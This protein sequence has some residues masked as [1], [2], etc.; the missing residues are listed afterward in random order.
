MRPSPGASVRQHHSS[1]RAVSMSRAPLDG[2]ALPPGARRHLF[3]ESPRPRPAAG[4]LVRRRCRA[5]RRRLRS[6]GAD[7]VRVR[8]LKEEGSCPVGH[9][10][11]AWNWACVRLSGTWRTSGRGLTESAFL[12]RLMIVFAE[13]VGIKLVEDCFGL[14]LH[15]TRKS[16]LRGCLEDACGMLRA[17]RRATSPTLRANAIPACILSRANDSVLHRFLSASKLVI[18]DSMRQINLKQLTHLSLR[19]RTETGAF[20]KGSAC[21][22]VEMAINDSLR[23]L[24]WRN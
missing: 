11:D 14:F 3:H 20:I 18:H 1:N 8:A 13:G 21:R 10:E 7:I 2:G 23:Q 19:G 5:R 4:D 22:C 12:Q 9:R 24:I 16:L 6:Q 17:P 15:F